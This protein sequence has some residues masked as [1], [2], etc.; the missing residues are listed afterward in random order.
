M[1]KELRY[2][3]LSVLLLVM[4][5]CAGMS[6]EDF[7]LESGNV[8]GLYAKGMEAFDKGKICNSKAL[9]CSCGA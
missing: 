5:G 8:E 9:F 4:V 1:F 6:D 7:L 2:M 3:M